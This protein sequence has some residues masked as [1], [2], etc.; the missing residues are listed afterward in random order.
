MQGPCAVLDV[1]AVGPAAGRGRL[2]V[3][4]LSNEP[5][6]SRAVDP[7]KP[8]VDARL[9][10]F[11]NDCLGVQ[12][13]ASIEPQRFGGR[14]LVDPF[15][16]ALAVDGRARREKDAAKGAACSAQG[17]QQV[18]KAVDVNRT[19]VVF[20]PAVGARDVEEVVE[21]SGWGAETARLGQIDPPRLNPFAQGLDSAAYAPD[22]AAIGEE[23]CRKRVSNVA[24]TG[25]QDFVGHGLATEAISALALG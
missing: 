5:R 14:S 10:R 15:A 17:R 20:V 13:N 9:G 19:V 21:G 22:L 23:P 24:T 12:K 8:H 6:S 16:S 7:R 18:A 11:P 3:P 25:D 4:D 1:N 2:A